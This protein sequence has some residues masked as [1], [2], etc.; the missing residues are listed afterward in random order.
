MVGNMTAGI[1]AALG[2]IQPTDK[3]QGI[4]EDDHFLMMRGTDRMRAVLVEMQPSVRRELRRKP[5]L[6]LLPV[7]H[8]EIPRQNVDMQLS[9]PDQQRME[10]FA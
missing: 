10:E 8:V 2:K 7:D 1:P 6:P 5:P 9:P 3:G 4:V